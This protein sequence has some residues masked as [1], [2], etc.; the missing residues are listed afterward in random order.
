MRLVAS[1]DESDTDE[2]AKAHQESKGVYLD[3]AVGILGSGKHD[4]VEVSM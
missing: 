4:L 3:E 2:R 1:N